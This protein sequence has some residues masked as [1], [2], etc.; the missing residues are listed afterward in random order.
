MLTAQMIVELRSRFD[1][2]VLTDKLI[3]LA[4]KYELLNS[5]SLFLANNLDAERHLQ[6]LVSNGGQITTPAEVNLISL[7]SGYLKFYDVS[8]YTDVASRHSVAVMV[9]IKMG[10]I[11][12]N[13]YTRPNSDI[14][15]CAFD[16]KTKLIVYSS[17]RP[18][19]ILWRYIKIPVTIASGVE[20]DLSDRYHELLLDYA[21]YL[22]WVQLDD[23]PR[24]GV[25]LKTVM[26]Q[27]VKLNPKT[28]EVK[29]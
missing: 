22:G 19:S 6:S 20:T 10:P 25:M 9:D 3:S 4:Q 14:L 26:A 17:P 29:S 13:P 8:D 7:P 16:G 28:E 2:K 5:A 1:E 23:V 18:T 24:A 27:I 15:T 12:R 11:L 21:E